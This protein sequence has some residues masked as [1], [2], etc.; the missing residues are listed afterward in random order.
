MNTKNTKEQLASLKA[1]HHEEDGDSACEMT[2][3]EFT[4]FAAFVIWALQYEQTIRQRAT[5]NAADPESAV[6]DMWIS[7]TA[8]ARGVEAETGAPTTDGRWF[9]ADV[10]PDR[11]TARVLLIASKG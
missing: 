6:R 10:V 3:S 7:L 5:A 9:A 11:E 2:F 4:R 8:L 1:A